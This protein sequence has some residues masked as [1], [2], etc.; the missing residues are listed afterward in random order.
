MVPSDSLNE[1]IDNAVRK[2]TKRSLW[3]FI[4]SIAVALIMAFVMFVFAFFW[5]RNT[6]D[7]IDRVK[8]N[9]VSIEQS[10]TTIGMSQDEI[11][12]QLE[13]LE[14]IL[15]EV[16]NR[17]V[18][19]EM[20]QSAAQKVLSQIEFS[21]SE[22]KANQDAIWQGQIALGNS[23]GSLDT[24]LG[25]LNSNIDQLGE[26]AAGIAGDTSE[27]RTT[28]AGAGAPVEPKLPPTDDTPS[29]DP[30]SDDTDDPGAMRVQLSIGATAHDHWACPEGEDCR[31][32]QATHSGLGDG[33]WEVKCATS[34]LSQSQSNNVDP[35][36][37]EVWRI[38]Q[39]TF[40]PT[41]GC[42][43]WHEGNTV[44][45]IMDGVRSNDLRWNP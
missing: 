20:S 41:N 26:L 43:Y 11:G 7:Q 35:E 6:T 36:K 18:A 15:G 2:M 45:V 44:Y 24:A 16:R 34:G 39:T 28:L 10:Q 1:S 33:P 8:S 22:V 31:W 19:I 3:Q 27:I 5:N 17:Q 9:Q 30:D 4:A 25:R 42:L 32:M 14:H 38:Y 40:N 29:P 37:H 23:L 13:E 21:Q 12:W